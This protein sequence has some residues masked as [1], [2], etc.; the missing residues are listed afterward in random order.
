M[1]KLL[2][3]GASLLI[4]GVMIAQKNLPE[5]TPVLRDG[6]EEGVLAMNLYPNPNTGGL[7]N[8]EV[9]GLNLET[10]SIVHFSIVDRTGH[11][12]LNQR[13]KIQELTS[14]TNR[15]DLSQI[16]PGIYTVRL[17]AGNTVLNQRLAI[18]G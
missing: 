4:C 6:I 9:S 13:Y 14:F 2:T 15:I 8:L 3:F 1:K 7:L 18:G 5:T 11:A 10:Q 17:V 16:P 12:R